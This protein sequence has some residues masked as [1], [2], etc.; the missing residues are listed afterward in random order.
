MHSKPIL[1]CYDG[2]PASRTAMERGIRLIQGERRA[3]VL[4]VARLKSA[5]AQP[6]GTR[7]LAG[8]G[9]DP[10]VVHAGTSAGGAANEMLRAE[11]VAAEGGEVAHDLGVAAVEHMV[12]VA[13]RHLW[14]TI[15]DVADEIDADAVVVGARGRSALAGA[16][17]GS[18]STGLVHHSE[19]PVLVVPPGS[20][21]DT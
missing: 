7:S 20:A 5:S 16:V 8:P 6:I 15:L 17:L 9:G 11:R 18:V 2:S 10:G 12:R 19:R 14:R 3:V 4:Y 13:D 1:F 21:E